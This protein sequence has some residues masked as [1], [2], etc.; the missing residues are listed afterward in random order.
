MGSMTIAEY[1]SKFIALSEFA[2]EVVATE[3]IKAQRFEQGLTDE[4]QLGLGGETF[5]SLDNVYERTTNIYGLQ[6]LRDE[7]NVVGKK[8]KVLNVRENQGNFKRNMNENRNGNGNGNYRGGNSQGH[9]NRRQSVRRYHCK[10]CNNNHPGKNCKGELVTCNY[11]QKRGHREFECFTKHRK[12]QNSNGG[13]NQV[14]FNQSGGQNSKP[15][16]AQNNQE[17]YNKPAND[18]NNQNK[19]PG[20]PFMMA[21]N[22]AEHSADVVHGGEFSLGDF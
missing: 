17:N 1:Y 10:R 8:R 11:C 2:P 19:A 22:E 7:K 6:S 18:N 20:K 16:G 5:T 14:R 13:G 4:I 12:E 21:R 9:N 15:G 3:E